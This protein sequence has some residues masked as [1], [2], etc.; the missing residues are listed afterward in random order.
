[1]TEFRDALSG[2]TNFKFADP[3]GGG[4]ICDHLTHQKFLR[5]T[6]GGFTPRISNGFTPPADN[7]H[8]HNDSS[9]PGYDPRCT[10]AEPVPARFSVIC[11]CG[12]GYY[13]EATESD[14]R[15]NPQMIVDQLAK[16]IDAAV[17]KI[18]VDPAVQSRL[19]QLVYTAARQELQRSGLGEF[20]AETP[21]RGGTGTQ[22]KFC[23]QFIP[24]EG[25]PEK[26]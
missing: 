4:L 7:I 13:L 26:K 3:Y 8:A 5:F 17:K 9:K 23:G 21:A 10:A 14:L 11:E 1:M 15:V 22:Q 20:L 2:V 16:G 25:E 24:L 12:R 6:I 19:G 18:C